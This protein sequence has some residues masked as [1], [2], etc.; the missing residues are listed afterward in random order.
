MFRISSPRV[1]GRLRPWL[2]L[3]S[4]V[5]LLAGC[6]APRP[7]LGPLPPGALDE[8]VQVRQHLVLVRGEQSRSL[9]VALRVDAERLTLI[10]LSDLGQRLFTLTSDG[11]RAEW[12]GRAS[13]LQGL[14]PNWILTELQLVYWPL[15]PLRAALPEGLRLDQQASVRTLWRDRELLW[16]GVRESG[17][18]RHG[19]VVVYNLQLGY[20]LGIRSLTPQGAE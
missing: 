15:P 19:E 2:A 8:E 7:W 20:R 16:F 4:A 10:G 6:A 1:P 14:D 17:D 13:D 9:Q 12:R 3:W 5:W 11:R 18:M